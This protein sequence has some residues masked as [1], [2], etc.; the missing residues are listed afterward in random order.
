MNEELNKKLVDDLHKSGFGSEMQALRQ[1]ARKGWSCQGGFHYFD[2]E[3]NKN[4]ETDVAA[5]KTRL[6]RCEDGKHMLVSCHIIA[7]V[8][9]TEKP[10][11]VFKRT[12]EADSYDAWN[13]L[14]YK[15]DLP[16]EE[17]HFV[18]PLSE[19]ALSQV[20]GW[21]GYAI[22]ESFKKPDV[23]SRWYSSFV[24]VCKAAESELRAHAG[25]HSKMY[26]LC[27]EFTLIK[28]VVIVDGMLV[29]ASLSDE[30]AI[31]LDEIDFAPFDF[32]YR[33]KVGTKESYLVDVVRL[34]NLE[35]YLDLAEK[36]LNA[37]WDLMFPFTE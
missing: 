17:I 9:K 26:P 31:E 11:I 19:H 14:I 5:A 20:C 6:K 36:R 35:S 8:K 28:P 25:D 24:T 13:N 7:E 1:F 18:E 21:K 37:V 32:S 4:Q 30:G 2:E 34:D 22:H 3:Q 33:S 10:W 12:M 29:G 16:C 23:L 27:H 15:L